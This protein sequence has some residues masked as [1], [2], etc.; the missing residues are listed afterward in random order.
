MREVVEGDGIP[1]E[2]EKRRQLFLEE[3]GEKQR[4]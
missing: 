3:E 4:G 1:L 2:L